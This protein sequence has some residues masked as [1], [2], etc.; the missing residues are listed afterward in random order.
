MNSIGVEFL[1]NVVRANS[2]AAVHAPRVGLIVAVLLICLLAAL[3]IVEA[4]ADQRLVKWL[5]DFNY[6]VIP[7]LVILG[8][9][10][11]IELAQLLHIL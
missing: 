2:A 3:V 4:F 1:D 11:V 9:L 5:H 6:A 8:V 7:L 10:V